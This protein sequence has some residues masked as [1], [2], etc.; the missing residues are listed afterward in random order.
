MTPH[1]SPVRI[2]SSHILDDISHLKE[3]V[4]RQYRQFSRTFN[5][6][7][8]LFHPQEVASK[9][10][11]KIDSYFQRKTTSTSSPSSSPSF[12]GGASFSPN[13]LNNL[14]LLHNNSSRSY[15]DVIKQVKNS[16]VSLSEKLPSGKESVV[17]NKELNIPVGMQS[18]PAESIHSRPPEYSSYSTNRHSQVPSISDLKNVVKELRNIVTRAK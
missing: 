7:Y 6:S 8:S 3:S 17:V 2:P 15:S 10:L 16:L 5:A 4:Q 1:I 9:K 18:Q 14:K 12:S 11:N 13:D